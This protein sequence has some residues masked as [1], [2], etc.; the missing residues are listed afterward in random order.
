VK[1]PINTEFWTNFY[2]TAEDPGSIYNSALAKYEDTI[3]RAEALWDWKDLSRGVKFESIRPAIETAEFEHYSEMESGKAVEALGRDLVDEE[4]L[5]NATVVTPAFLLHLET[6]GPNDYCIKY[7]I[8]D[9]RVWTAYVY[10]DR[11]RTEDESLPVGATTS[12]RKY[13][14]FVEFFGET[15][16]DNVDGRSYEVALFRFGSYLNRLSIQS[17]GEIDT[18][19]AKIEESINDYQSRTGQAVF[20]KT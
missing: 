6:S 15:I 17:I 14:D 13:G 7:P 5:S 11:R 18:H 1:T 16:S 19:L 3:N 4:A 20:S 8:F 2:Q 9:A 10:L 12:A